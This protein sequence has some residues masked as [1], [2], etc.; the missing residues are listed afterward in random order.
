MENEY[1]VSVRVSTETEYKL[2]SEP[3]VAESEEEAMKIAKR[4]VRD[5]IE[6]T[7]DSCEKLLSEE[8]IKE[9]RES[10]LNLRTFPSA[11]ANQDISV[12]YIFDLHFDIKSEG[13]LYHGIKYGD[14]N[15]CPVADVEEMAKENGYS[16]EYLERKYGVDVERLYEQ[17]EEE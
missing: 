11:Y 6:V 5:M 14:N 10:H 15:G 1:I 7:A 2:F 16:I 13:A 4:Y 8:D 3:V 9:R 17:Y 12:P